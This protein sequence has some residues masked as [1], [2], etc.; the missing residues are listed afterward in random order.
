MKGSLHRSLTILSLLCWML[1]GCLGQ[2][3]ALHVES[4]HDAH[5]HASE[6]RV[7]LE[8]HAAA[9]DSHGHQISSPYGHALPSPRSAVLALAVVLLPVALLCPPQPPLR[10]LAPSP[11]P[12]GTPPLRAV[13]LI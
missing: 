7:E 1:A 12:R 6:H 13:L 8:L 5:P 2:F 10:A 4:E 9:S 11:H 3:V